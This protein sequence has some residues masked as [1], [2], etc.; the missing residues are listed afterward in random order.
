[1]PQ[2]G[3]QL[4]GG[5]RLQDASGREVRVTSRKGRALLAYLATRE[6]EIC[7]RD[8]LARL[9][10]DDTD[11]ELARTSLRQAL[12][13]LRKSLPSD[14]HA[15][16][17]A[18]AESVRLDF[19]QVH[20][21]LSAFRRCLGAGTRAAL[22]EALSHYRGELLE[23][24]DA[25]SSAFDEW[26]STERL[27]LRRQL[28]DALQKLTR[29][30]TA[31]DDIDGAIDSCTR[32]VSLEPLNEAAHRTLMELHAKRNAFADALR[33]YRICRDA[34]RRELDVA[35]EPATEALYR[36]LMRRRRSVAVG[37]GDDEL[38]LSNEELEPHAPAPTRR[39]RPELREATIL[40]TRLEGLLDLE[41]RLDPEEAYALQ[42]E[43]QNRVERAVT[44]YGGR[45]DRRVGSNVL[46]VFGVPT[47]YGNEAER[48]ARAALL[49]R[50]TI[51]REPWPVQGELSLRIGIAQGQ[52]LSGPELFP[53]T[54]R[55]TRS[56]HALA[57]RA[58]ANEILISEDLRRALGEGVSVQS[59]AGDAAQDEPAWTLQSLRADSAGASVPFV[60]RRP[61]LAMILA[62]LDRCRTS[63]HGRAIV[64]RGEAGIGKSR[65]VHAIRA[66]AAERGVLAH[67]AQ[68]FDF[69]QS[70]SHRPVSTLALSLLGINAEASAEER[71]EAARRMVNETQGGVDQLIFLSDLVDAPLD[72][73]LSALER[74]MEV[75]T[76]QR[77]R[78]LVLA[79]LIER[80]A[81]RT[82]LLIVIEDV[83]WADSDELARFGE[84]AATVANCPIL[85]VMT[86]RPEG[87]PLNATWRARARGCP[88][89]TVD[90]APLAEDEAQELAAH[91]PDVPQEVVA[92]CIRRSEGYPLFLDQLLRAASGGHDSLPGSVRALVL[93]RAQRLS[94]RDLDALQAGAVLGH[95]FPLATLRR[96]MDDDQFDPAVLVEAALVR[97]DGADVEFAHALFRDAV[98]ESTL[99][100]RRRELHQRAA[101]YF[102]DSDLVLHADHLAAADSPDAAAAYAR[103]ARAELAELRF[104]RALG[105][106]TKANSFAREPALLQQ[107]SC[108]LGEILLQLGRTHD[109]L[110]AYREALE[111]AFDQHGHGAAWLGVA[112]TLRI[113]DR[114]EEALEALDKAEEALAQTAD[115]QTRARMYT[116]RGNLCFPLGRFDACLKAHEQAH[117]YALQADSAIDIAHALGGLGD[118][119]YQ[120]GQMLTARRQFAQ[121]VDE[122][123]KHSIATVLLANL[124]MLAVTQNFCCELR[125]AEANFREALDL[126][127]RVGDLRNEM[128]VNIGMSTMFNIQGKFEEALHHAQRGLELSRHV[129]ARR[130]QAEA[131]GLIS[132]ALLLVND[133]AKALEQAEEAVKLA[134]ETG[135]SYC[136]PI[137]LALVARATDDAAL[138]ARCLQEGEALLAAGCVSHSY[139]EFYNTAMEVSLQQHAWREARRYADELEAYTREERLL[140]SDLNIRRARLL[141]DVGEGK[142]GP[143]T[144]E[145]LE[146]LRDECVSLTAFV[147]V[148]AIEAGIRQ[149]G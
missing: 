43:F 2:L 113:M 136:G 15:V 96:L 12:T 38:T 69:G 143:Q 20:T 135:M 89:T 102:V 59:A 8:R 123:R 79:Q 49:L 27:A 61:E 19:E 50:D 67:S 46:S 30:C 126:A 103:A 76:R 84:I 106:A 22:Q 55:P 127:K 107:T 3:L 120:R 100:S 57:A 7:T 47:A 68:V 104:E 58:A 140:W 116:L 5:F 129:G 78:S 147:L 10:W 82:P 92:A 131:L 125:P 40:V 109:A 85:F 112:S 119:Y 70:P 133:R 66:A 21:D 139:L 110:T 1:V 56:A 31:S 148:P 144:R 81:Q 51:G 34:L 26:L 137:L 105:L 99:K 93:A 6:S 98:Y 16:L 117:R 73:E 48:A 132:M 25:K 72:A 90:L 95:R 28:V 94:Q 65:L 63:R 33:Q 97:Y 142:T 121:C 14:A 64:I 115:A 122:G 18:D 32:L 45:T 42:M 111:F 77:G 88:V 29:L 128:L 17:I 75:T 71:A 114:H 101:Q 39:D 80:A 36:E 37:A 87:D 9:L 35:P 52:V 53:L 24:F 54:G 141:S 62:V 13:A 130:F 23:S 134:R 145:A 124:P 138:R 41:A 60:G 108:L 146:S 149:L 44:E 4:L 91:Y 118:A 86:T 74:A 11:E 83:H